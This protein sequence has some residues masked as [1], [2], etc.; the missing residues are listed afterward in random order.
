MLKIKKIVAALALVLTATAV[1]GVPTE[2]EAGRSPATPS[3]GG[4]CC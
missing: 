1:S 4:W 3:G 2:A